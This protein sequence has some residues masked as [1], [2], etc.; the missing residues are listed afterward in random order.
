M[1]YL[2]YEEYRGLSIEPVEQEEFS[3]LIKQANM[4]FNVATRRFYLG[5]DFKSDH[6][7][8]QEAVK[9]ALAY[10]VDYYSELGAHTFEGINNTPGSVSLGRT[11][12]SK[13]VGNRQ[14][15]SEDK[16]LL[17]VE[18]QSILS[19]TGLLYRGVSRG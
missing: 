7:W 6:V 14:A 15:V 3:K 8:R 2:N 4:V 16:S 18:A 13:T 10:Q 19:G 5:K 11:S 1:T 17:S 9:Q 12:I